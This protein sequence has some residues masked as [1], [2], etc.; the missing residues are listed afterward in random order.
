[1]TDRARGASWNNDGVCHGEQQGKD[2]RWPRPP[3]Y[4]TTAVRFGETPGQ[5]QSDAMPVAM[6]VTTRES[7]LG[8][9]GQARSLVLDF[10]DDGFGQLGSLQ[11]H[12]AGA[13]VKR[14]IEQD[15]DDL[16]ERRR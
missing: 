5:S 16:P 10:D 2:W 7:G 4:E 8:V 9:A 3:H 1:M 12:R 14:V 13:M 15:V 6:A 11:R